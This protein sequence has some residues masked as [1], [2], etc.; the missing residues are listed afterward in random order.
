LGRFVL[1]SKRVDRVLHLAPDD[2]NPLYWKAHISETTEDIMKGAGS[3]YGPGAPLTPLL[4]LIEE[5]R[6]L[7]V[8]AKPCDVAAVRNLMRESS[9]AARVVK[10]VMV[11]ACG[12]ASRMTKNWEL[13]EGWDVDH[14][15]VSAFRHRGYGNPG[16]TKVTLQNGK[17][18]ETSYQSMWEDQGTWDL[19]WRC[20]VCPDGMGEVADIVGLDCW[21]GGAPMG[22]DAGYDGIIVRTTVG[23]EL[24]DAAVTAGAISIDQESLPVDQTLES[25]QPHQSRRKAAVS[26]RL[27]GMA[28]EGLPVISTS[29]L[30]LDLAEKRLSGADRQAEEDG[31]RKRIRKGRNI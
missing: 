30:R 31:A 21:P 10:Y 6:P 18:Q 24:I 11:M 27:R 1:T 4:Q 7:A 15:A 14:K 19:Q 2:D 23:E 5:G 3:R 9:Q 22:E 26:S 28:S 8:I 20:K 13:F 29:G 17:T 25:W 12:G 16:T